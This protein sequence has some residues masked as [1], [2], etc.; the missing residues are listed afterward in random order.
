MAS[1][2]YCAKCGHELSSDDK[3]CFYCGAPVQ[4]TVAPP[5]NQVLQDKEC[6]SCHNKVEPIF[7]FCPYC[8]SSM[9]INTT[10]MPESEPHAPTQKHTNSPQTKLTPQ[11]NQEIS[12]SSSF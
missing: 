6:P 12:L 9:S 4:K 5:Q 11:S 1:A 8:G 2:I 3:F 7:S 10:S